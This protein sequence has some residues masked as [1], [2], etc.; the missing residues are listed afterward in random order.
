M[1]PLTPDWRLAPF[2]MARTGAWTGALTAQMDGNTLRVTDA[3]GRLVLVA[4]R[5]PVDVFQHTGTPDRLRI[6]PRID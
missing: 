1:I 5:R 2:C 3:Q 4:G 6:D